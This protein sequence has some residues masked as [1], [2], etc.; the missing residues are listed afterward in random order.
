MKK[1]SQREA[2]QLRKEVGE[3]KAKLSEQRYQWAREWPGGTHLRTI[4]CHPETSAVIDTARALKHAV[5]VV[6]ERDQ[7]KLRLYGLPLN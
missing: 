1:I 7:H 2:R 3:L 4:Q 6:P 5:V